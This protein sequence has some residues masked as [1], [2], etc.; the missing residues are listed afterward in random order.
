MAHEAH[1]RLKLCTRIVDGPSELDLMLNVLGRQAAVGFMLAGDDL[2][3]NRVRFTNCKISSVRVLSDEEKISVRECG[4]EL[5]VDVQDC[6]YRELI[7]FR[8]LYSIF[9]RKGK[10][11]ELLIKE[12]N[13]VQRV[14][15][16]SPAP[17]GG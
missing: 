12:G 10:I 7:G 4:F 13:E 9:T 17:S 8:I 15:P 14:N 3:T 1:E 5:M 16:N 6:I 11:S 2:R